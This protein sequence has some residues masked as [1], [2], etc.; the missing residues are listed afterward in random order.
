MN[1][2][3]CNKPVQ[4]KR[5]TKK[6]CSKTCKQYAYLNRNF[7]M[8]VSLP[9]QNDFSTGK[10]TLT[11]TENLRTT[12]ENHS[13]KAE[14][15]KG[16]ILTETENLRISE[17][18]YSEKAEVQKKATENQIVK[19]V[20][21]AQVYKHQREEKK[22]YKNIWPDILYRIQ[23]V[24]ISLDISSN[25]F[26][27]SGYGARITIDN[28]I[29]FSFVLPRLRCIIE[30]LFTL[31]YKRKVYHKTIKC[32]HLALHQTIL[33]DQMKKMPDGFPF[34]DDVFTLYDK[35]DALCKILEAENDGV[36]FSLS[37]NNLARLIVF[38]GLFRDTV[39]KKSFMELFPEIYKSGGNLKTK[40]A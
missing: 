8:P 33:T 12:E 5:N 25:Y 39:E 13:E 29:E 36:K 3:H 21:P 15:Q 18:N 27:K 34:L 37:K 2:L 17:G 9:V 1:C 38:L 23:E 16:I 7:S 30:N 32:L 35:L 6:Y 28:V 10:I 22:E 11:E 31:C 19:K 4:G 26:Q 40:T 24:E 20:S 14:T